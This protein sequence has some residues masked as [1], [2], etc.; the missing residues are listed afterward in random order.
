MRVL[1]EG[2]DIPEIEKAYIVASTTV[3]RQWVQRRGRVLR[4]CDRIGKAKATLHDFIVV[5]PTEVGRD[6]ARGSVQSLL[7]GELTRAM[8]FAKLANNAGAS[9]GPVE[10][11]TSLYLKYF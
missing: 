3:E 2:I 10:T 4:K 11:L 9:G 1:D 6:A 7:K 5:P 8:E